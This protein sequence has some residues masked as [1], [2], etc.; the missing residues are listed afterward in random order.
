MPRGAYTAIGMRGQHLLVIPSHRAIIVRLGQDHAG[1]AEF[2]FAR[3]AG[4]VLEALRR[5]EGG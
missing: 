1:E 5:D 3:F 4:D 2:D